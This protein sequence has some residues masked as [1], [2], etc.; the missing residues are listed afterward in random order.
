MIQISS[1]AATKL[2][3]E[4][5]Q[6]G[7]PDNF[8]VRF[9]YAARDDGRRRIGFMFAAKPHEGDTVVESDG[10]P[11]YLAPEVVESLS[12][13]RIDVRANPGEPARLVMRPIE[14]AH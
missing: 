10:L 5:R 12:G 2:A 13:R 3:E 1:E 14:A 11:V 9:L 8:G 4:R 6:A 7:A